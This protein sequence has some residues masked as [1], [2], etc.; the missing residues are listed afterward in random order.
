MA[1]LQTNYDIHQGNALPG[2]IAYA[3][4]ESHTIRASISVAANENVEPGNAVFVQTNGDVERCGTD[5]QAKL[6]VGVLQFSYGD[7]QSSLQNV[8]TG[9]NSD[10]I[11]RYK[12]GD[13]VR[14]M[15]DGYIYVRAGASLNFMDRVV[16][17][18]DT[19]KW[20]AAATSSGAV[21]VAVEGRMHAVCM[22]KA[23]SNNDL[24]VIR[25]VPSFA[26]V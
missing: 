20:I 18:P 24:M 3:K 13:D 26:Q 15:T 4:P 23:V 21:R 7:E 22:D 25:V 2:S 11:V 12:N 9:A 19:N 6:A 16:Y 8:P 5:A 17:D 14:V 1:L 10:Q